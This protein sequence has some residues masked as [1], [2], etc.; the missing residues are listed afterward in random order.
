MLFFSLFVCWD[1]WGWKIICISKRDSPSLILKLLLFPS[2][3]DLYDKHFSLP[4]PQRL[5]FPLCRHQKTRDSEAL[6]GFKLPS[7][8]LSSSS[9]LPR[10]PPFFAFLAL[11]GCIVALSS[12]HLRNPGSAVVSPTRC[13]PLW[14][15]GRLL[16]GEKVDE[17]KEEGECG[18][19]VGKQA[20]ESP[21]EPGALSYRLRRR[22]VARCG[23]QG[24]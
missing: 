3:S 22:G 19:L 13:I 8:T 16:V 14:G 23:H 7:L 9:F 1:L 5:P 12:G 18:W 11:C 21:V 6:W 24:G 15:R 20:E 2:S 10:L 17:E 4:H